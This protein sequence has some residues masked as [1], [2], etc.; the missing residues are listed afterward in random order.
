MH[1]F[2][3]EPSAI[4]TLANIILMTE[5]T[6]ARSVIHRLLAQMPGVKRVSLAERLLRPIVFFDL[7]TTGTDTST[8]KIVEFVGLKLVPDGTT[9]KL[10]LLVNPNCPIPEAA[11]AIHGI[12]NNDSYQLEPTYRASIEHAPN[13]GEVADSIYSFLEGAD[14]AGF[15]S[16]SFDVPLLAEEFNRCCALPFPLPGTLMLDA[17]TIYAKNERRTL[18]DALRFYTGQALENAHEASADVAATITILEAQLSHYQELSPMSLQELHTYSK[19]NPNQVDL[20]GK[21]ALNEEGQICWTFGKH[22]GKPLSTDYGYIEWVLGGNFPSETKA[23]L[24][25]WLQQP[26][27]V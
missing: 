13:F 15:N 26:A 3:I 1:N 9:E 21:L 17:Y 16:N 4:H 2:T 14:L 20:A 27:N 6:A 19:R 5:D 25:D 22:A 12:Y 7:E 23:I 8:S 18:T 10:E 24:R 11:S